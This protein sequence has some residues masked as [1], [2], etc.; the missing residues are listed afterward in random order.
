MFRI[1][2]FAV[3]AS[4]LGLVGCTEANRPPIDAQAI[5]ENRVTYNNLDYLGV[6]EVNGIRTIA[7]ALTNPRSQSI[8]VRKNQRDQYYGEIDYFNVQGNSYRKNIPTEG[9]S[10]NSNLD[11]RQ[12]MS[13]INFAIVESGRVLL[14]E[15]ELLPDMFE[16][17]SERFNFDGS[18]PFFAELKINSTF[19]CTLDE[20]TRGLNAYEWSQAKEDGNYNFFSGRV[21]PFYLEQYTVQNLGPIYI[22][23]PRSPSARKPSPTTIMATC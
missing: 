9:A 15:R 16:Y 12:S 22:R 20:A 13:N 11:S 19:E 1:F 17:R 6:K 8:C 7:F 23:I 18:G 2:Y 14:I 10:R 4:F 5:E 21:G 3:T